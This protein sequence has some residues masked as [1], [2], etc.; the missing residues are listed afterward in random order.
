MAHFLRD[1]HLKNLTITPDAV[2]AIFKAFDKAKQKIPTTPGL[3]VTTPDQAAFAI[4]IR[5]DQ[6]GK[7]LYDLKM[8]E[9]HFA[10]ASSVERLVFSLDSKDALDRN[11]LL[12]AYM[13]VRLDEMAPNACFLTVSADDDDWVNTQFLTLKEALAPYR[14]ANFLARSAIT[15]PILQLLG[16][17]LLFTLCLWASVRIAAHFEGPYA[18]ILSFLFTMLI[19]SNLW[20]FINTALINGFER[21]FPPVKMYRPNK[22]RWSFLREGIIAALILAIV[23]IVGNWVIKTGTETIAHYVRQQPV[24]TGQS[25]NLQE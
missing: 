1:E 15:Q 23:G 18:P 6:K 10:D 13:E 16:V 3:A 11:R 14:N 7:R 25:T 4:T 8:L 24:A 2:R 12:G 19:F 9:D 21:L 22:D 5:Y 20:G 17:V